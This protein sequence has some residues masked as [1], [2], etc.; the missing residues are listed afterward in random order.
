[1]AQEEPRIVYELLGCEVVG[2]DP[3]CRGLRETS[4]GRAWEVYSLGHRERLLRGISGENLRGTD[5]KIAF[6]TGIEERLS[7]MS[8]KPSQIS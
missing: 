6:Q 4:V 8:R 7:Q 3:L 2:G 5:E 1:M